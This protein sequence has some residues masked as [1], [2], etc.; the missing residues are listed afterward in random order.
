[1]LKFKQYK[2]F[3]FENK[4]E[5]LL[6]CYIALCTCTYVSISFV[7]WLNNIKW[8]NWNRSLLTILPKQTWILAIIL[9]SCFLLLSVSCWP[10]VSWS[11]V[12]SLFPD[13]WWPW[14]FKNLS[15]FSRNA[16][17]VAKTLKNISK[18]LKFIFFLQDYKW[19]FGLLNRIEKCSFKELS[20]KFSI[21]TSKAN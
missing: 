11:F 1:M 20:T 18:K 10:F 17:M 2:S 4:P 13:I 15:R 21:I 8:S 14:N 19:R 7:M 6:C 16:P 9:I 3:K 5:F 12:E